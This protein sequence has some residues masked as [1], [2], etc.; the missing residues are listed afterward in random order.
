[1]VSSESVLKKAGLCNLNEM[2]ASSAAVMVWKS[3]Q[4]RDPLGC[5][6]FPKR[7]SVRP[8]RSKNAHKATQ[9]VPG[10]K[11]LAANLMARCW[12]NATELHE[13]KT[14]GEAKTTARKWASNLLKSWCCHLTIS[15][16]ERNIETLVKL[17]RDDIWSAVGVLCTLPQQ[18]EKECCYL[19]APVVFYRWHM[20]CCWC[21]LHPSC[22]R[23]FLSLTYILFIVHFVI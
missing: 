8:T 5:C 21:T 18:W 12:N 14:L 3:K 19:P 17:L 2:V 16:M 10:N 4:S 13:V 7:N 1:M 20:E 15:R 11:T 23:C 9:P 22:T 6:L